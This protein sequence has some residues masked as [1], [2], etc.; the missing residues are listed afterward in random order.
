MNIKS[1]KKR[2][3]SEILF[4]L[5]RPKPILFDH[6]PKC[7]GNSINHYLEQNYP[8]R[9][10]FRTDG[11]NPQYSVRNFK[12]LPLDQR[13]QYQLIIGH[14]A[15]ELKDYVHPKAFKVTVLREPVDRIVS[16]YFYVKR[17]PHHYLHKRVVG[18]NIGLA[19]YTLKDLSLELTNFYTSHFS[20]ISSDAVSQNPPEAISIA[21]K[22][23]LTSYNLIGFQDNIQEFIEKIRLVC[24]LPSS[25]PL[26]R[27]NAT[28]KR[29]H[30]DDL[31]EKEVLNI[32][33]TN[34]ADI[35]FFKL[36][37]KAVVSR[38]KEIKGSRL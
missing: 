12:D 31:S 17:N 37:K 13:L 19:E 16:H 20:G 2:L 15:H 7:G 29:K 11:K 38:S 24:K 1:V 4:F 10:V 27:I 8:K 28:D 9:L 36:V 32:S 33:S 3:M 23:I 5:R 35:E 25:L 6:L 26:G 21:V 34:A 30:L 14:C 22:N 18:E